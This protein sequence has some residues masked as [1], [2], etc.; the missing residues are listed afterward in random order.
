MTRRRGT[1]IAFLVGVMTAVSSV[2]ALGAPG[3]V[4]DLRVLTTRA[5]PARIGVPYHFTFTVQNDGPQAATSVALTVSVGDLFSLVAVGFATLKPSVGACSATMPSRCE[6]GVLPPNDSEAVEVTFTPTSVGTFTLDGVAESATLDP[7]L[8]SNRQQYSEYTGT[9]STGL[10]PIDDL[11]PYLAF[12]NATARV[13]LGAKPLRLVNPGGEET[14]SFVA[15]EPAELRFAFDR[16]RTGRRVSGRCAKYRRSNASRP[17][18]SRYLRVGAQVLE[19][20]GGQVGVAF[21]GTV[22]T[23][24]L[25]PGRYRVSITPTDRVGNSGDTTRTFLNIG[26]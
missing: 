25:S 19:T 18:C 4:A 1:A 10:R 7:D 12:F 17:R 20:F 3:D 26:A 6:I 8:A 21:N 16:V 14:F 22:G 2:L 11:K 15:S 13:S 23:T 24:R 5:A 9:T